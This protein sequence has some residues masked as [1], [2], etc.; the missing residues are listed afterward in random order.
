M[1]VNFSYVSPYI[2]RLQ[3]FIYQSDDYEEQELLRADAFLAFDPTHSLVANG[4]LEVAVL[5]R[6][7]NKVATQ[8]QEIT[9]NYKLNKTSDMISMYFRRGMIS[10]GYAFQFSILSDTKFR[11]RGCE[12]NV[13]PRRTISTRRYRS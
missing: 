8:R 7:M 3:T 13:I 12:F 4:D 11:F 10:I 9:H 6:S 5:D 1:A 2:C